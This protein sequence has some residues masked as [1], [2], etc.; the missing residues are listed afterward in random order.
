MRLHRDFLH[1]FIMQQGF[2]NRKM[3]LH[4]TMSPLKF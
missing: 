4:T 3:G 1:K 2:V